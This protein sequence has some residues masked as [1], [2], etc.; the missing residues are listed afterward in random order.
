VNFLDKT[1]GFVMNVAGGTGSYAGGSR[2]VSERIAMT[3]A[4]CHLE[5]FLYRN[6]DKDGTLTLQ[7]EDDSRYTTKLW[8]DTR[9]MVGRFW[10][11]IDVKLGRR[12][13]G[14]RLVFLSTHVGSTIA[15]DIS[16]DDVRFKDCGISTVGHCESFKNPF[17]CSNGNCID[18]N[19][20]C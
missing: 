20:V 19:F 17:N 13:T 5:F 18:Q 12:R 16:I 7:M 14:F 2:L 4:S 8:T 3:A 9:T 6:R 11:R 15:S 1:S 10:T